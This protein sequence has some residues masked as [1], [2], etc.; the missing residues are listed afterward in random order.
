MSHVSLVLFEKGGETTYLKVLLDSPKNRKRLEEERLEEHPDAH[1]VLSAKSPNEAGSWVNRRMRRLSLIE[2]RRR[3][4]RIA[5]AL[6]K[7]LD[8]RVV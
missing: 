3:D 4:K 5:K 1:V 6:R 7:V 2:Q 8:A